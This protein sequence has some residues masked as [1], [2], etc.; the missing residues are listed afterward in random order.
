M[1]LCAAGCWHSGQAGEDTTLPGLML[2]LALTGLLCRS[3]EESR[4]KIEAQCAKYN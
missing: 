3:G 4:G 1:A 2:L